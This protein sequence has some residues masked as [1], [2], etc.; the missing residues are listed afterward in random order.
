MWRSCPPHVELFWCQC[1]SVKFCNLIQDYSIIELI[2]CYIHILQSVQE[3]W[4]QKAT[5]DST[6][7]FFTSFTPWRS[8]FRKS[9]RPAWMLLQ[10]HLYGQRW[11]KKILQRLRLWNV[12][13]QWQFIVG[14]VLHFCHMFLDGRWKVSLR[15]VWCWSR[16]IFCVQKLNFNLQPVQ[17]CSYSFY[18]TKL[19]HCA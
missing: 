17:I 4:H 13:W 18:T 9:L 3:H 15:T 12:R 2:L 10:T 19:R 14:K 6:V 7:I 5:E 11:Q 8:S 16:R 1:I